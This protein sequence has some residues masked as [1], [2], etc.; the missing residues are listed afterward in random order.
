MREYIIPEVCNEEGSEPKGE[1]GSFDIFVRCT[2]KP[3]PESLDKITI[4]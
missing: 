4:K 1:N 2:K 3:W